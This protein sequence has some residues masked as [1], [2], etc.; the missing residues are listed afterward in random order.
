MQ[1]ASERGM[2][3]ELLRFTVPCSGVGFPDTASFTVPRS[4]VGFPDVVEQGFETSSRLVRVDGRSLLA[5]CFIVQTAKYT[6]HV[7]QAGVNM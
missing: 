5:L 6:L 4:R 1:K 7:K 3:L 2:S